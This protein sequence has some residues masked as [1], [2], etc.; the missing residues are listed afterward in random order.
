MQAL[1]A[2][3]DKQHTANS[4]KQEGFWDTQLH[5]LTKDLGQIGSWVSKET[6]GFKMPS[7]DLFS[8]G[9]KPTDATASKPAE[10][11][12]TDPRQSIVPGQTTHMQMTVDG[13]TRDVY[14]HAPADYDPKKP[15]P[16]MVVFNG[17]GFGYNGMPGGAAGMD[18]FTQLGKQ[19]DKDGFLVVYP[20]GGG[21]AHGFNNGQVPG[22]SDNDIKFTQQLVDSFTTDANVDKS[23]VY[24]VGFSEGASF[25]H[26][27]AS[28][29][30]G[31]VAAVV[32]V[33]GDRAADTATPGN[34]I[35]ELSIHSQKDGTIPIDGTGASLLGNIEQLFG[36]QGNSQTATTNF[37]RQLDGAT[38]P[39]T[40]T[41]IHSNDGATS[42]EQ[43]Y[44][45][46]SNGKEVT[47]VTVPNLQHGWAGSSD[48]PNSFSASAL[49]SN[50]LL[51]LK[52]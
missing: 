45:N 32:D 11:V 40:T 3:P 25:A 23:K 49:I 44:L 1:E 5:G 27:A 35:S 34:P 21:I 7:L 10:P 48:S 29:M 36:W 43:T 20:D 38:G 4:H 9:S 47:Q 26:K 18:Q 46:N 13:K 50:W 2:T 8:G 33:A 6:A 28:A 14:V 17:M 41:L 31:Q 15:M 16:M 39:G 30:S 19:A 24:F 37:Y 42:T 52:S 12:V 22:D 51:Q